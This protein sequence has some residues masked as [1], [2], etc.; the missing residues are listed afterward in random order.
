MHQGKCL[1]VWSSL[2]SD[3]KLPAGIVAAVNWIHSEITLLF[4]WLDL[5]V[6]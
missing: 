5:H 4:G 6:G 1:R 2:N 3:L